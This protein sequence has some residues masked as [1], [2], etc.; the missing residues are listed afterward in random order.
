[1][2]L[3]EAVPEDTE[4]VQRVARESWHKAHGPIFGENGVEKLLDKWY[5]QDGVEESIDRKDAPMFLAVDNGEV[6]GFAQGGPTEDGPA[7]T[8]VGA[9]Y[10]LPEYWGEGFGTELLERLFDAF[11]TDDHKSVWLAV[12]ADNDVGRSFYDKHGFEIHEKRTVEL[13]DQEVDDIVLTREL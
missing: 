7:D 6:V 12:M 8:A 10:V 11:R 13:A 3:R 1:M 9:I 2:K 5:D 4:S